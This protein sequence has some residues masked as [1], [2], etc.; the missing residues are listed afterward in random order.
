[1]IEYQKE[2]EDQCAT[3]FAND[4]KV[5]LLASVSP[6]G[7]PHAALITTITV[8]TKKSFT[9][10]QFSA[11]LVKDYLQTNPKTGFLV[12]GPDQQH[13]WTGAGLHT[14]SVVKG[15]DFIF[16]NNKPMFRYNAYYGIGAVHY[17]DLVDVSKCQAFNQEEIVAGV[18]EAM[19]MAPAVAKAEGVQKMSPFAMG[20]ATGQDTMKFL[21]YVDA[22]G[23]PRILPAFQSVPADT[24]RFVVAS[25]PYGDILEKIPGGAK[26]ALLMLNPGCQG[27]LV[28]G[29]WSG[30]KEING[31]KGS[32]LELDTVYSPNLPLCRYIYPQQPL[33]VVYGLTA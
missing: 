25:K 23:F 24:N 21:S 31:F 3:Q 20:M 6:E 19:Q 16:F 14:G 5:G 29:K 11:G 4:L 7:Y 8:K 22:D 26:V 27:V 17:H 1:M 33:P 9:W 13:W 28:Q 15:D 2:F 12:I 30:F 10:G 18:T 32:V